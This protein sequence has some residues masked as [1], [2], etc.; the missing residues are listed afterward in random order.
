MSSEQRQKQLKDYTEEVAKQL[1]E[2]I[3]PI[4]GGKKPSELPSVLA[5]LLSLEKKTRLA[6]DAKSTTTVA[7]AILDACWECKDFKAL[8][9]NISVLTKRRAQLQKVVESVIQHG[10]RLVKEIDT[11]KSEGEATQRELIETL[12]TVSS[13]KMFVELE[14]AQLTQL[15]ASMDERAGRVKEAADILQEIQVETI[16]SMPAQEKVEYLLEQVRLVLA[17]RDFVRTEIIAKKV[18]V[19]Q[20]N[21][22]DAKTDDRWQAIKIKYYTLMIEYHK[23]YSN[24]LEI[25]KAY[26][27][28]F[29]TN[30]IQTDQAQWRDVLTKL[31]IYG[32]LSPWDAELSDILHRISKEKKLE[33]LPAVKS[34]LDE[35][36]GSEVMSWPLSVADEWKQNET[37]TEVT[38]S[39]VDRDPNAMSDA[40]TPS[41]SSVRLSDELDVSETEAERK[42]GAGS[43]AARWNDL[44][45]RI[46]QHNIR[47]IGGYYSHIRS[48]RLCQLLQLPAHATELLLSDMVSSGQLYAKIDRPQGLISFRRPLPPAEVLN[49]YANDL[50]ALLN[51]VEKT[52]HM[53]NKENMI[54]K[55]K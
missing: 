32:I 49:T 53:I 28:I 5:N 45:K 46:V 37:F 50:S 19:K 21:E 7:S 22:P 8:N 10:A 40:P 6:A 23:H 15:L 54:H 30:V 20:F 1:P 12:R 9:E 55:I 14:R 36:I 18:D 11:S 52:C 44:H 13:G 34:V 42:E 47:V 24:Y 27:E 2:L 35:F 38:A 31:V 26:R 17:K 39:A 41:S 48:E 4:D 16:G 33:Q 3:K 25:T 29:H 43:G 51:V